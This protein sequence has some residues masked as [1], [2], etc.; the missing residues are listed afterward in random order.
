MDIVSRQE[1]KE[2]GL[3]FYFTG[4]ACKH[5]HVVERSV[6][7]GCLACQ[8][9]YQQTPEY[10]AARKAYHQKPERKAAQKAY[11]QTPEYKA[12]QKEYRKGHTVR[13]WTVLVVQIVV[14]HGQHSRPRRIIINP[15]RV[16]S[17]P[18]LLLVDR[19][20]RLLL[21]TQHNH[22]PRILRVNTMSLTK[23][24]HSDAFVKM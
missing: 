8:K 23:T 19:T 6:N 3:K 13:R 16:M 7:S 9:A 1:A 14:M 10:K 20:G 17:M 22:Q 18:R 12:Y 5:G 11:Q 2:R 24:F 4:K 21:N 15:K